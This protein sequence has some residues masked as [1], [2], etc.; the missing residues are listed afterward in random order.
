VSITGHPMRVS[1]ARQIDVTIWW[2][3]RLATT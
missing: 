2:P 3:E 1:F